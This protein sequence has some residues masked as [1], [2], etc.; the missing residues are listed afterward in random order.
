MKKKLTMTLAMISL[1]GLVGCGNDTGKNSANPGTSTDAPTTEETTGGSIRFTTSDTEIEKG[2]TK[3]FRVNTSSLTSDDKTVLFSVVQEGEIVQLAEQSGGDVSIKVKG[4][5]IGTATLVATSVANTKITASLEIQV[6]AVKNNLRT[7]WKKISKLD[8][9][10]ISSVNPDI[11]EETPTSLI[12]VTPDA[13]VAVDKNGS[14]LIKQDVQLSEDSTENMSIYGI[15]ISSN[16]LAYYLFQKTDGSFFL[17]DYSIQTSGGLLRKANFLGAG[18][19]ASSFL[20][21]STFYGLQA[22]NPGWLTNVKSEDNTYEIAG[23]EDEINAAYAEALLWGLVDP[24]GKSDLLAE[25]FKSGYTAPEAA[26]LIDTTITVINNDTVSITI[27]ET[28]SQITHVATLTDKGTTV[29]DEAIANQVKSGAA[30]VSKPKLNSG[31]QDIIATLKKDDYSMYQNLTY[32]KYYD[33]YAPTYYWNGV[34]ADILENFKNWAAQNNYSGQ[35][36][37]GGYVVLD[38]GIYDFTLK[39]NFEEDGTTKKEPTI[40]IGTKQT[41]SKDLATAMG[42]FSKAETFDV[43]NNDIAYTF[44]AL[45]TGSSTVYYSSNATVSDE[46]SSIYFGGY[47]LKQV[48]ESWSSNG[49]NWVDYGTEIVSTYSF[50]EN[51]D[52]YISAIQIGLGTFGH[53][54]KDGFMF[55]MNLVTEPCSKTNPYDAQIKAAM[56]AYQA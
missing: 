50:D 35:L 45:S 13:V 52:A 47:T 40:T 46:L 23:S 53:D 1:L 25:K 34:T 22:I 29:L 9:Y 44:R 54:G 36:Q 55:P 2:Y 21:V 17:P 15:A 14:A 16:D 20:E 37:S 28:E 19:K 10:T 11:D 4:L 26:E 18:E 43:E 38:D 48:I 31:L 8:N 5:R 3:T 33:Y 12:K 51:N 6:V 30:S 49:Y 32:G 39:E 27:T 42:Y 7:V 56:A 41:S 24:V